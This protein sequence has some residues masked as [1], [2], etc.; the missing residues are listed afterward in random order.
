MT[1]L[2]FANF[3]DAIRTGAKLTQ[4]IASGNITVTILQLSNI[5]WEVQRELKLNSKDGRILNDAE[6]MRLWG[7]KYEPGWAPHL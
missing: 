5:A 3:I 6:A 7:R 1:D 4:P 2:H